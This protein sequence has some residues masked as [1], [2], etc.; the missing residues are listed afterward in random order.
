[1]ASLLLSFDT[2]DDNCELMYNN[3]TYGVLHS[4]KA[5]DARNYD[6]QRYFAKKALEAYNRVLENLDN[7]G[8]GILIEKVEDTIGNLENAIDPYDWDKGRY[9]S[10]KV[11]LSSL[12]L[13]TELDELNAAAIE[14][15]E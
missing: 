12:D 15:E 9:Y 1:M 14:I 11:Y 3:A 4:K 7:C 8:C 6:D 13:V 10:K 2:S 5:F